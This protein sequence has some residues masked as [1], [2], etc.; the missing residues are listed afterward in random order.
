[1]S[2]AFKTFTK[3]LFFFFFT[4]VDIKGNHRY[5]NRH[6]FHMISV[7]LPSRVFFLEMTDDI[8][9][10]RVTLRGVDPVTGEW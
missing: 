4:Q 2:L 6:D 9:I 1:M 7:S 10:E 3:Q 5:H 8:A